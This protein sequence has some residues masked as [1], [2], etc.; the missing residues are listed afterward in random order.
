MNYF[1]MDAKINDLL[2][3]NGAFFAFTEQQYNAEALPGVEYK[4]LYAGMLCPS[5]NVK[6]V[7]DGMDNLSNEKTQYELANNSIKAIIWDSLANY[8]CQVTG[9]YSDA[10]EALKPYGIT[11]EVIKTE[12]PAYYQNCI[13]NDFF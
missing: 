6:T 9:D 2:D 5:D 3:A 12:W 1:N 7:M 13:D 8:E 4:R 10:I 11:E